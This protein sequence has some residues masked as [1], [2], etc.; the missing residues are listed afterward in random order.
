MMRR[1]S[2]KVGLRN[3]QLGAGRSSWFVSFT[4]V[5]GGFSVLVRFSV[6]STH[7]MKKAVALAQ[8]V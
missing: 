5:G 2:L 6:S 8:H 4:Q 7:R 3:C 1:C